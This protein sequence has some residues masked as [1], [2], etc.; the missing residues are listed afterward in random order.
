VN[1]LQLIRAELAT[2]RRHARDLAASH[3]RDLNDKNSF[4]SDSYD[5]YFT[6]ILAIESRRAASHLERLRSRSDLSVTERGV[7]E[8]YAGELEVLR[9]ERAAVDNAR[10][11]TRLCDL[12]TELEAIAESRYGLD[13]WR[14]A[15]HIDADSILEERRLRKQL[16]AQIHG[17]VSN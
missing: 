8:R 16:H 7:I 12:S 10:G 17:H 5:K 6:F 14:R 15:A 2:Q 9:A 4:T 11:V 3:A 13:D 1:E